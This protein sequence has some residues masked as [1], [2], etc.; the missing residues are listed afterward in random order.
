MEAIRDALL[1]VL[2]VDTLSMY[3]VTGETIFL[4]LYFYYSAK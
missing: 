2:Q 3:N 4:V 1:C